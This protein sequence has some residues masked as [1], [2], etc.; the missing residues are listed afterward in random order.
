MLLKR[1]CVIISPTSV[2]NLDAKQEVS[3]YSASRN[4]EY[5]LQL[6]GLSHLTS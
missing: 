3:Y 6:D 2:E 4:N 5:C 1:V